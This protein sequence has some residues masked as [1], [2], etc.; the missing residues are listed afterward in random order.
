[1]R[2]KLNVQVLER[3]TAWLDTGTIEALFAANTYVRAI[4]QR[5]GMKIGCL[6]EIAWNQ[7]WIT[8]EQL[9]SVALGY[10]ESPYGRYLRNLL[11]S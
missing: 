7:G 5:Q 2:N 9:N 11:V 4:E 3:G 6:E 10:G 1:M 8:D